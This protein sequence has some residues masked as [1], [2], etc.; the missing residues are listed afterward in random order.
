MIPFRRRLTDDGTLVSVRRAVRPGPHRWAGAGAPPCAFGVVCVERRTYGTRDERGG[1]VVPANAPPGGFGPLA[2]ARSRACRPCSTRSPGPRSAPRSASGRRAVQGSAPRD[3]RRAVLVRPTTVTA[4]TPTC[5]CASQGDHAL[6]TAMTPAAPRSSP[7]PPRGRRGCRSTSRPRRW[8]TRRAARRRPRSRGRTRW[9]G[10]R[11]RGGRARGGRRPCR[12]GWR[13][14]R[15][16]SGHV[17]VAAEVGPP[18][19]AAGDRAVEAVGG[20]AGGQEGEG[21]GERAPRGAHGG[22]GVARTP[23]EGVRRPGEAG[24]VD[25]VHALVGG[26]DQRPDPGTFS[27]PPR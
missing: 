6:G 7:R 15:R 23:G 4:H 24:R 1:E 10:G 14:G 8:S 16:S 12:T 22:G 26:P 3:S 18:P 11:R 17:E 27:G 25:G 13:C 2:C 20:A 5:A 9:P 21:G 19:V